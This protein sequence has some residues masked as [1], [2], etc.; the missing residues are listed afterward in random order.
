MFTLVKLV[1][2]V[3]L[4]FT[5]SKNNPYYDSTAD[6]DSGSNIARQSVTCQKE[7][8][9]WLNDSFTSSQFSTIP[10][11]VSLFGDSLLQPANI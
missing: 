7:L 3:K 8:E 1:T 4:Y 9:K 11:I 10:Q 6:I 5:F 2:R